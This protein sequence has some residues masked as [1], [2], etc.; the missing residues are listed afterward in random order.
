[1]PA[2]RRLAFPGAVAAAVGVH[3]ALAE[4]SQRTRS[5]TVDEPGHLVAGL[6]AWRGDF[7]GVPE[8]PPLAFLLGTLPLGDRPIPADDEPW[9]A[10]KGWRAGPVVLAAS[11]DPH[12]SMV[13]ARRAGLAWGAALVVLVALW[14]RA[15]YGTQAGLAGAVL[16]A[17]SPAVLAH[18]PLLTT[19]V[20]AAVAQSL[21]LL[22][23]A[24]MLARPSAGSLSAAATALGLALSTKFSAVLLGP[25]L[26]LLAAWRAW[27]R[28]PVVH[29]TGSPVPAR[30]RGESPAARLA[31]SALLLALAALLALPVVWA[32]YGFRFRAGPEPGL[33]LAWPAAVP[34]G[35]AGGALGLARDLRLLP[36]A[37]LYGLGSMLGKVPGRKTFLLGEAR[38]GGQP[39]YF[40]VAFLVKSTLATLALLALSGLWRRRLRSPDGRERTALAWILVYG[41]AAIASGLNIGE[42]HLLPIYPAL[43]VLA[44]RVVN[45]T[46]PCV[47]RT[48]GSDPNSSPRVASLGLAAILAAHAG[49]ALSVH[50]HH[51]A[52]FN[53]LAGGPEGGRRALLDS[54]LDWGQ[55]LPALAEWARRE[56][57]PEIALYYFGTADP[58]WYG[59]RWRPLL[60]EG[61]DGRTRLADAPVRAIS[62]TAWGGSLHETPDVTEALAPLRAREPDAA[63]GHSILV[64]RER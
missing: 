9:R 11:G 64:F 20:P 61:P 31:A 29:G 35:L 44:S 45:L 30:L 57:V 58:S 18:G 52:Y 34:G 21:A 4:S 26:V 23:G 7:R 54:N 40:P 10:G 62:A 46:S 32:A 22:G 3:L 47:P 49:T 51:L 39:L 37:W 2:W 25:A 15:W 60:V 8:H 33:D 38:L 50:P 53:A 63:I 12:G 6:A 13:A 19:D 55:D 41:A 5:P 16:A 1:M 42:R 28:A 24:R 56:G 48:M 43:F 27:R 59:I 36:E 14:A 17:F